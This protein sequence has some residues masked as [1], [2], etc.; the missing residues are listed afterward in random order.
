M[1]DLTEQLRERQYYC[2][3]G[4]EVYCE[5]AADLIDLLNE[6]IDEIVGWHE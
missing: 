3:N 2:E 5:Q 1:S 6:I 4:C